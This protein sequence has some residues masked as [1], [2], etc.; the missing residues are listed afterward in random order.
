MKTIITYG[1]YDLFH[2]G[3][4][5][6]LKRAKERG[7]YLIVGVTSDAYDKA[8]G[9]LNVKQ[10]LS[11]RIENIKKTGLAD[12]I[13]VEEY[14]GQK[15][16]DIIKYHVDEFVLGSDWFGK[17]DYLKEYCDVVYLER[18]KGVSSTQLRNEQFGI[19]KIGYVGSFKKAKNII[20]ESK[21]VSGLE[22]TI[23]YH[24]NQKKALKVCKENM[25]ENYTENFTEL[26][27]K[28]DALYFTS[29]K[30][31]YNY[32]RTALENNKHV[33]FERN[34][35]L[36][37][38]AIFELYHLAKTK[39]LTL[40]EA[41]NT[42]YCPGFSR[43]VLMIK[44]GSIGKVKSIDIT[45]SNRHQN[46]KEALVYPLLAVSKLLGVHYTDIDKFNVYEN[47]RIIYQKLIIK[48]DD[49]IVT[50]QVSQGMNLNDELTIIGKSGYVIVEKPWWKTETFTIFNQEKTRKHSFDFEEDGT[51]YELSDFLNTVLSE[52][53]YQKIFADESMFISKIM[54]RIYE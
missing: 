39:Q 5:N 47:N 25:L 51:R 17:F 44:S 37:E 52:N 34:P 45:Y 53:S 26:L 49:S 2:T 33:L 36:K 35:D 43:L 28:V 7:D 4:Y 18:T 24:E 15:I 50:I 23:S 8:R 38:N 21:Y 1:T 42:I 16:N 3:H 22:F 12:K 27:S 31:Q 41:N 32:I 29:I 10:T 13:I 9:K 19:L 30:N 40:F 46:I 48:Y 6:I 54:E 14:M 20:L 11:E